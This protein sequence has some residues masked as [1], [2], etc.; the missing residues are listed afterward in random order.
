[1]LGLWRRHNFSDDMVSESGKQIPLDPETYDPHTC[2]ED[3]E[4]DDDE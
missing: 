2:S 3:E 4:D 1:M